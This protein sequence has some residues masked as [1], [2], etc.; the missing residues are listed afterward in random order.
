MAAAKPPVY[1]GPRPVLAKDGYVSRVE[2]ARIAVPPP[3]FHAWVNEPGREL[4]DLV[5]SG[6]AAFTVVDTVP[7]KGSAGPPGERAGHRRR[8]AFADGNFLAEEILVDTP[9]TFTY[10]IWGFTGPQRL[11]VAHGTAQ[12]NYAD[13]AGRT[14]LTWVYSMMPRSAL[15]RPIVRRVVAGP[16]AALMAA[17]VAGMKA[18]AEAVFT[19]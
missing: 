10:L 18:G 9:D 15:T 19:T 3:A 16:L 12:F 2:T 13:E 4:A 11:V 6:A 7:L 1:D 14:R 5:K 17:T 8:V